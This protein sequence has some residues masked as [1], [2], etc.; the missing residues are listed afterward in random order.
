MV[1]SPQTHNHS[2]NS[3][4]ETLYTHAH[5][6]Q[7][8]TVDRLDTSTANTH[9]SQRARETS[10]RSVHQV[11]FAQF[12]TQRQEKELRNTPEHHC[13]PSLAARR[14]KDATHQKFSRCHLV[15]HAS[16]RT[17]TPS[18]SRTTREARAKAERKACQGVRSG[19]GRKREISLV[20][21]SVKVLG[22]RKKSEDLKQPN[23]C[24]LSHTLVGKESFGGSRR[25]DL[26]SVHKSRPSE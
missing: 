21:N 3:H 14:A 5:F 25:L 9:T 7:V 24:V 26:N 16:P 6:T 23:F 4:T 2:H 1:L 15:T 13:S 10:M 22:S 8:Q 18:N 20:R 12:S 19:K 11:G 17:H